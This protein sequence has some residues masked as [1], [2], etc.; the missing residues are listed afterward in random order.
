[1]LGRGYTVAD[2]SLRGIRG[3]SRR[4]STGLVIAVVLWWLLIGGAVA[5][6]LP[7]SAR[8]AV[9]GPLAIVPGQTAHIHQPGMPSWPVPVNRAGFDAFQRGARESDEAAMEEA[10]QVSAWISASHGQEVRIVAV[11]GDAVQIELL[12]GAYMGRRAWVKPRH[13]GP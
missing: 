13:L 7:S 9:R 2:R 1:M 6:S 12:E 8:S 4:P 5:L 11:D 3:L 10:F